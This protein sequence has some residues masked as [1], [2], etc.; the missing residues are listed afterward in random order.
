MTVSIL[1]KVFV[2]YKAVIS[3]E[4]WVTEQEAAGNVNCLSIDY[5]VE[6]AQSQRMNQFCK[7]APWV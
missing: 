4:K 6:S 5:S 1:F 3:A 2:A 7:E